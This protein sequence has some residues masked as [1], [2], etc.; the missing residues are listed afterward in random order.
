ML[1]RTAKT[2]YTYDKHRGIHEKQVSIYDE[3]NRGLLG[4]TEK[5]WNE[6]FKIEIPKKGL[7]FEMQNENGPFYLPDFDLTIW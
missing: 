3:K 4:M 6:V 5:K 7:K 1:K 2:W